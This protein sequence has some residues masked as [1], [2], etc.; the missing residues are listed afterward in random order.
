MLQAIPREDTFLHK[1]LRT[2]LVNELINLGIKD[3][4]IL[5]SK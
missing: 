1:G 2:K 5:R 4:S 3:A